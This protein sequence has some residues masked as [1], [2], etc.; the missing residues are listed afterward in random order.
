[1]EESA[2]GEESFEED[3][4]LP[5]HLQSLLDSIVGTM[6][7]D[8][9][10]IAVSLILGFE[11]RFSRS[12][13]GLLHNRCVSALNEHEVAWEFQAGTKETAASQTESFEGGTSKTL[14]V[15]YDR[16]FF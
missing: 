7:Q 4:E 15:G 9:Q 11:D 1:M 6:S 10:G 2:L 5:E 12:K 14:G 16:A 13:R 3:V 8:E